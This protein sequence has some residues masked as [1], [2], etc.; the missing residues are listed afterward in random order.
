MSHCF[1]KRYEPFGEILTLTLTLDIDKLVSVPVYLIKLSDVVKK[2]VVKKDVYDK[3]VA[4][5]NSNDTTGFVLKTKYDKDKSELQNKVPHTSGLVKKIDSDA[6]ITEIEGKTPEVSNLVTKTVLTTV[7]NKIDDLSGLTK[8]VELNDTDRKIP[9][10]TGLISK[11]D[12][13]KDT[14]KIKNNY[15][16]N[17]VLTSK[18]ENYFPY[19]DCNLKILMLENEVEKLSFLNCCFLGKFCFEDDGNEIY[20]IFQPMSMS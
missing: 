8:K 3:L 6:K 12:L 5:L 17:S 10:I 16:T 13:D 19:T 1:S 9:N 2:N 18:L 20:L 4:N 15:V 11:S 14:D 7:E